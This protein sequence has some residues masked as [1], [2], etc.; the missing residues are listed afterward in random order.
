[1]VKIAGL[2]VSQRLCGQLADGLTMFG[3]G[4]QTVPGASRNI[5]RISR[6]RAIR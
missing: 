2:P 4:K 5:G 6:S 1:M 3:F